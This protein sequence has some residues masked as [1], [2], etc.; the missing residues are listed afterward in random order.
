[1]CSLTP[2]QS[3]SLGDYWKPPSTLNIP[4]IPRVGHPRGSK[5][6]PGESLRPCAPGTQGETEAWE[7]RILLKVSWSRAHWY[8]IICSAYCTMS[9]TLA[10]KE[11]GGT[12]WSHPGWLSGKESACNADQERLQIYPWL[13]KIPWR[14]A[15]QPIPV[16][17]PWQIPWTE[18]PGRLQSILSHR[19]GHNRSNSALTHGTV[20]VNRGRTE[21]QE[22]CWMAIP[23]NLED[24]HPSLTYSELCDLGW[25][26]LQGSVSSESITIIA[27]IFWVSGM[28]LVWYI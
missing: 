19:V 26:T 1:M 4:L 27:I 12:C 28:L 9:D 15:W 11:R 20:E 24:I 16:F 5:A 22:I 7:G 25:V 2:T 23:A 17:L 21:G 10:V 18:V 14:R 3:C 6:E 13:E 8:L